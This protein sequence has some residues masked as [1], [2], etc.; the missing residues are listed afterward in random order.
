MPTNSNDAEVT[1]PWLKRAQPAAQ[2][3]EGKTAKRAQQR[4][5]IFGGSFDPVHS[6]HLAL[7]ELALERLDLDLVLF[8]PC[9]QSPHKLDRRYTPAVHRLAMLYLALDGKPKLQVSSWELSQPAPSF[10]YL[11]A[12]YFQNQLPKAKLFWIVGADQWQVLP[13]WKNS[14]QL[15]A[16]VEFIVV[17]RGTDSTIEL[18]PKS[19][20][21]PQGLKNLTN[22]SKAHGDLLIREFRAHFIAADLPISSSALRAGD[23]VDLALPE[24]Q[25]Y[26]KN[27]HLYSPSDS[28]GLNR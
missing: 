22:V 18:T 25:A 27:H 17:Q 21:N 15:A 14:K 10:S 13:T 20:L 4:V 11:T 12:A 5:A 8:V 26:R 3:I 16:I 2:A 6:G 24:V 28:M 19:E 9:R 7:A 23:C 1:P